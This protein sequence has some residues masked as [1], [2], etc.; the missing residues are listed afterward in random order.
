MA[1]HHVVDHVSVGRTG[2]VVHRPAGVDN[3]QLTIV[4]EG[5]DLGLHVL[6]L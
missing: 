6:A 4:D 5:A 3:L 2:L 1:K